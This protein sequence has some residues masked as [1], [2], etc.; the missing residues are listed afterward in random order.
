VA[1]RIVPHN[2]PAMPEQNLL[3]TF[4]VE[5]MR[6][7]HNAA[8]VGGLVVGPL[9]LLDVSRTP[10]LVQAR[11][12]DIM[13]IPPHERSKL[14]AAKFTGVPG[15]IIEILARDPRDRERDLMHKPGE[16]AFIGV[17]EYWI[18]DPYGRETRFG[19]LENG[20]YQWRPWGDAGAY[21][22]Q[23]FSGFAFQEEWITDS[24]EDI[25]FASEEALR[26]ANAAEERAQH[27]LGLLRRHG[28]DETE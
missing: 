4:V 13:W 23:S 6:E 28:I 5:K 1:N 11:E 25:P 27:Y 8:A 21:E 15:L 24:L 2:S 16:Y 19:V 18:L 3:Q 10:G 26:R 9:V 7:H 12:P 22:S 14:Q 20:S 17:P